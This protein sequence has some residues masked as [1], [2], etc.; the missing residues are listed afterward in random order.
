MRSGS[1][2]ITTEDDLDAVIYI[3]EER[4][5]VGVSGLYR[6]ETRLTIPEADAAVDLGTGMADPDRSALCSLV[7][8][9]LA[10]AP[11]RQSRCRL[12]AITT[13]KGSASRNWWASD[14]STVAIG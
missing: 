8:F 11:V 9:A 6:G 4:L 12:F 13:P 1:G 5:P 14:S 3:E 7:V 10:T 2:L